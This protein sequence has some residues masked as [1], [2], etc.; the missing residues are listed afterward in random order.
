MQV[1]ILPRD[2]CKLYSHLNGCSI[3]DTHNDILGKLYGQFLK[4]KKKYEK[5]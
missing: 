3:G 4:I 2:I 5:N 1:D